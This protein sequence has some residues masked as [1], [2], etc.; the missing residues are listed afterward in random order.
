MVWIWV[1]DFQLSVEVLRKSFWKQFYMC[2]VTLIVQK[3]QYVSFIATVCSFVYFF[4]FGVPYS[5]WNSLS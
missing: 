5:E 1:W 4:D 3:L 2:L